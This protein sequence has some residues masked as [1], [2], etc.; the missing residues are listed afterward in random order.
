MKEFSAYQAPALAFFSAPFY[1]DLMKNGKGVGLLYLLLLT[2]LCWSLQT[3]KIYLAMQ[4]AITSAEVVSFLDQ[5]PQ[6]TWNSG[7]LTIDK[8]S[9]YT[10]V[11]QH[12]QALVYFDLSGK[13]TALSE[14]PD[15]KVLIT[16]D[17]MV[18]EKSS[19]VQESIPWNKF[20]TTQYS[21]D[22]TGLKDLL[23]KV[24]PWGSLLVWICGIFV[25]MGHAFMALVLGALGI[26]LFDR[27]KLGFA[28][29]MRLAAFAMTPSIIIATIQAIAGFTIPAYNLVGTILTFA[30]M[31][32]GYQSYLKGEES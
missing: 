26:L 5:V 3:A 8:P 7:T 10:I 6:M 15:A 19:G 11:D 25:W 24:I 2:L 17:F 13:T 1:R 18:A 20:F 16:K 29:M 32:F 4:T 9:P 12:N 27:K 21:I 14:T 28:T 22:K 31:Y 30:F 23:A